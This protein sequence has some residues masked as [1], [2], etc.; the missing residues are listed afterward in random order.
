MENTIFW[1]IGVVVWLF[2]FIW[3]ADNY[4]KGKGL[5]KEKGLLRPVLSYWSEYA[6]YVL[7]SVLLTAIFLVL[8]YFDQ[9]PIKVLIG[10]DYGAGKLF[11]AV[12]VGLNVELLV[13][14]I[15]RSKK[16]ADEPKP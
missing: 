13:N 11:M 3:N 1:F 14:L 16:P 8:V 2:V 5:S 6:L 12:F 10:E 9:L 7:A 15:R 4:N